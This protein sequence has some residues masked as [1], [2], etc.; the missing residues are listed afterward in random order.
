MTLALSVLGG[1]VIQFVLEV[2]FLPGLTNYERLVTYL[3]VLNLLTK[4]LEDAPY[5][6]EAYR[7]IKL[8]Y[9]NQDAAKKSEEDNKEKEG[10]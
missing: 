9:K 4:T 2:V 1:F 5:K 7:Q 6:R 3:L 8:H 10:A